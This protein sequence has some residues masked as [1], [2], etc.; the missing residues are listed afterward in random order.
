MV[1]VLENIE[2]FTRVTLLNW[3]RVNNVA[4]LVL[5]L[6][7]CCGN[8]I[9]QSGC[10]CGSITCAISDIIGEIKAANRR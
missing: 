5:A 1:A 6:F 7:S 2:D 9:N 4:G 8:M 3:C 10:I